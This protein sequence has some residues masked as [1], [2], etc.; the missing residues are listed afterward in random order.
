MLE[1]SLLLSKSG[2]LYAK[3]SPQKPL[4]E[5][6][7][8]FYYQNNINPISDFELLGIQTKFMLSWLNSPIILEEGVTLTSIVK[9][10]L[11]W[12]DFF[13]NYLNID[14]SLLEKQFDLDEEDEQIFDYGTITQYSYIDNVNYRLGFQNKTVN[15]YQIDHQTSFSFFKNKIADHYSIEHS[16]YTQ[17]YKYLNIPIYLNHQKYYV[18]LTKDFVS[19]NL[20]TDSEYVHFVEEI[21]H[22]L[23]NDF[24]HGIFNRVYLPLTESK[25]YTEEELIFKN[26]IVENMDSYYNRL[27]NFWENISK[28][29]DTPIFDNIIRGKPPEER[30]LNVILKRT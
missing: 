25:K 13:N 18:F 28:N 10:L 21:P 1:I 24:L 12:K 11:P 4:I 29:I 23:F 5:L 3:Y 7:D 27:T 22:F 30:L 19:S 17:F 26:I 8:I 14:L 9:A 16:F 2:K 15:K 6:S 20:N